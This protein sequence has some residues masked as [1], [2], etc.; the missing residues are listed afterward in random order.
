MK[1]VIP[2]LTQSK[3]DYDINA[4]HIIITIRDSTHLLLALKTKDNTNAWD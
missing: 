2:E 1:S 4:C 3:D